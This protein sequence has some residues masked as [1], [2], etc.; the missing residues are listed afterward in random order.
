MSWKI[1]FLAALVV[2]PAFT[3][4]AEKHVAPPVPDNLMVPAGNRLFI[5]GHA[6]G[7]QNYIC[8]PS[9]TAFKWVQFGPQATLFNEHGHQIMTHFLSPNPAENGTP[10]AAWQDSR[11]TSSVWA[12]VQQESNDPQYVE[13]DAIKWLLLKVVGSEFG[14]RWGDRLAKTTYIQ[15]IN[16]AGG[17]A[18]PTGCSVAEDVG[19]KV[20]VPYTTD[21]LFYRAAKDR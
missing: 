5:V 15:R 4:A 12:S 20:L 17:M 21:Y 6:E 2:A 13:P 18:P 16:T 19:R 8:L 9:G 11:D 3:L 14:P 7:T 1:K 10:R